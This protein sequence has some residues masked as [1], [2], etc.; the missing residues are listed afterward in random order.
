MCASQTITVSK[1]Y[2]FNQRDGEK[3]IK[4]LRVIFFFVF[5]LLGLGLILNLDASIIITID[6]YELNE[7]YSVKIQD[8]FTSF[9]LFSFCF[10]AW[11]V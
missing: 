11:F 1:Y 10:L 7:L 5:C 9:I 2:K 3:K 6:K 4:I 8:N